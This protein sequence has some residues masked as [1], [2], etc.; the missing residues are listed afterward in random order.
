MPISR[1]PIYA[2]VGS[3][4]L[5]S[6]RIGLVD[7]SLDVLSSVRVAT[8]VAADSELLDQGNG[9]Y[10]VQFL[11]VNLELNGM[12]FYLEFDGVQVSPSVTLFVLSKCKHN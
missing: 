11:D 1:S 5:Y 8:S 6:Y 7:S 3:T 4:V 12:E 9:F 2:T 10:D